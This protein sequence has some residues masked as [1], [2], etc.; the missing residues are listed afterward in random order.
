MVVLGRRDREC[1]G[2][3]AAFRDGAATPRHRVMQN[4]Q[5]PGRTRR[6][7]ARTR[8]MPRS[9]PTKPAL[10]LIPRPLVGHGLY[11]C[12]GTAPWHP[13]ASLPPAGFDS[14]DAM[15]R[16]GPV[17]SSLSTSGCTAAR[18]G[19]RTVP[20]AGHAVSPGSDQRENFGPLLPH[21]YRGLTE[22]NSMCL[23]RTSSGSGMP[24]RSCPGS[25]PVLL[26][27]PLYLCSSSTSEQLRAPSRGA[28]GE[29]E[30]HTNRL[31]RDRFGEPGKP[32]DLS[33][34]PSAVAG[35][36]PTD[37]DRQGECIAFCEDS[38]GSGEG[39]VE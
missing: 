11:S 8:Q 37:S 32:A 12:P 29:G 30:L 38:Q 34:G 15:S 28:P 39:S 36:R 25:V 14:M 16:L 10:S 7:T 2:A 17:D 21:R 18:D 1:R 22:L 33:G 35:G 24:L 19:A 9:S 5:C 4:K 3:P 13:R 26:I 27:L 6:R 23:N 31:R 20:A